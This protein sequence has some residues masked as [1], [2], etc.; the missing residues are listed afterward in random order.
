MEGHLVSFIEPYIIHCTSVIELSKLNLSVQ[1]LLIISLVRDDDGEWC[2]G[3]ND[4]P[5]KRL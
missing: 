3:G 4:T 2:L 1:A 5:T